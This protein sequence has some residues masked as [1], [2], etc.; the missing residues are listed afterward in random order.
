MPADSTL[1]IY[2]PR[3]RWAPDGGAHWQC[4]CGCIWNTFDTTAVC[5]QCRYR[6]RDT[7]CPTYPGGCGASSPHPD[8]YHGL[9]ETVAQLVEQALTAPVSVCCTSNES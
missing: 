8:W 2:C 9:D 6:H 4:H 1:E 5:P 3:C 7:Q